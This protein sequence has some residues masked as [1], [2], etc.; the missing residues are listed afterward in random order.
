MLKLEQKLIAFALQSCPM[1]KL[2]LGTKKLPKQ[3]YFAQSGRTGTEGESNKAQ[4]DASEGWKEKQTES[5]AHTFPFKSRKRLAERERDKLQIK[6]NIF[7][8]V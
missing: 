3:E 6:N 7:S 5:R 1:E 4:T 8:T 2:P